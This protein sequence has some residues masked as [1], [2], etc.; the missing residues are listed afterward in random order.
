MN[1][2]AN[3]IM[4]LYACTHCP[5]PYERLN[6]QWREHEYLERHRENSF[7]TASVHLGGKTRMCESVNNEPAIMGRLVLK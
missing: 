6:R 5:F 1:N 2:A 4:L 3:D 7:R